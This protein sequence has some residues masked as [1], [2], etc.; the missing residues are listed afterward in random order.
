[1]INLLPQE[2]K[3]ELLKEEKLKIILVL[4]VVIMSVFISQILLLFLIK[5]YIA[6]DLEIQKIYSKER[7]RELNVPAL[8]ELENKIKASDLVFAKLDSFYRSQIKTTAIL[9]KISQSLP[10]GLYLT[11]LNFNS[12]SSQAS[13]AG[14]TSSREKLLNLRENLEKEKAFGDIYFPPENW[15][16]PVDINFN[17]VFKVK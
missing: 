6:V 11:S 9:E 3:E 14:F 16:T 1:M 15:V 8:K 5:N 2:Q 12:K 13:L 17:V 4:G 7:E 10:E